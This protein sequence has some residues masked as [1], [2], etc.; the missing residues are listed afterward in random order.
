LSGSAGPLAANTTPELLRDRTKQF[1][2]RILK[3][4]RALPRGY[5]AQTVGKQLFRSGTSVAANYR[6][7]CR[8]RSQAEFIAKIGVVLEEVNESVFWLEFL[9][10]NEI[11]SA[12][13]IEPLL[14]EARELAAIFAAS[15]RTAKRSSN[16]PMTQ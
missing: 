7:V 8:A 9:A 12:K 13:R 15:Q 6:A 16:G 3:L 5:E 4:F 10:E 2:Y 14:N 1:A 11:I